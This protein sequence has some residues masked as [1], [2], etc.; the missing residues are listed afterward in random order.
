MSKLQYN[1]KRIFRMARK[2]YATSP[3]TGFTWSFCLEQA[4]SDEKTRAI[5]SAIRNGDV[6][7][8]IREAA[9]Q[10]GVTVPNRCK[11]EEK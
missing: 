10:L 9:K 6:D 4:W 3:L 5:L 2:L 8:T 11:V 1:R 7:D